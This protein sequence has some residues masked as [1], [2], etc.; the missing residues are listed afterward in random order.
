MS[1]K[2]FGF[3]RQTRLLRAKDFA[4]LHKLGRRSFTGHFIVY[5][6]PNGLQLSR[7]GISI[8]VRT[9]NAVERNK[10]KRVLREF[11]RVNRSV[12]DTPIDIHIVVKRGKRAIDAAAPG[13]VDIELKE[14][15]KEINNYIPIKNSTNKG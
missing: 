9:G 10:L 14:I 4:S 15:F 5:I 3:P 7:L 13:I 2:P 6:L 12:I 11:F 1:M 8:N